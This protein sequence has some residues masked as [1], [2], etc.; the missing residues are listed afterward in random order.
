MVMEIGLL[1]LRNNFTFE[2]KSKVKKVHEKLIILNQFCIHLFVWY[3]ETFICE[4]PLDTGGLSTLCLCVCAST[5]RSFIGQYPSHPNLKIY[6][7]PYWLFN[8]D[9]S[10]CLVQ[11]M[12]WNRDVC[13]YW[14]EIINLSLCLPHP[15]H[16]MTMKCVHSWQLLISSCLHLS[17]MCPMTLVDR[18]MGCFL[19]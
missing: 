6:H 7:H 18:A 19:G 10:F 1:V 9:L 16:P 8:F 5:Q 4:W 15:R 12:P 2:L 11:C 3:Y 17:G 14:A 13:L